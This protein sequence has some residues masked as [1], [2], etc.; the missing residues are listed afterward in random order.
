MDILQT[1]AK[2]LEIKLVLLQAPFKRRLLMMANGKINIMV[3]LVKHP[4]REDYIDFIY[5]NT[6]S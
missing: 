6:K 5:C 1:I 4:D 2:R 3:G